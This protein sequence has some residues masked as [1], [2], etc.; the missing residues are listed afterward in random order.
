MSEIS[1]EK[2]VVG[3]CNKNSFSM[4]AFSCFSSQSMFLSFLLF[5]IFLFYPCSS[6]HFYFI[7][8][9]T[10]QTPA[11]YV[12]FYQKT[13]VPCQPS[14]VTPKEQRNRKKPRDHPSW[15][16]CDEKERSGSQNVIFIIIINSRIDDVF[17]TEY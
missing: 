8:L 9:P 14:P 17:Y 4:L 2:V 11:A 7:H 13:Q 6:S 1:E 12:L 10:T 15:K 16:S 5:T 3:G